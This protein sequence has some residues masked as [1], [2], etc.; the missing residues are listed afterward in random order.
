MKNI[1][2]SALSFFFALAFSFSATA[3]NCPAPTAKVTLNAGS[4]VILETNENLFSPSTTPGKMVQFR[5][6]T[7]VMAEG[8]I[9][10]RTG[11]MAVGRVKTV[12]AGGFSTAGS[13]TV[14]LFYVQAVDGQQVPLNGN[15]QTV[16]APAPNDPTTFPINS[17][18]T[19]QV[20]NDMDIKI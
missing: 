12:D 18:F 17:V 9:A 2:A 8:K 4:L 5:V 3:E 20:M 16:N 13:V 15:E 19:S 1:L 6:R 7:N 14:E 10:I 11:A